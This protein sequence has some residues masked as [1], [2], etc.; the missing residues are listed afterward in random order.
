MR[1]CPLRWRLGKYLPEWEVVGFITGRVKAG[2]RHK[3]VS[4][5]G[6]QIPLCRLGEV[7]E[8]S[9]EDSRLTGAIQIKA[10]R[11]VVCFHQTNPQ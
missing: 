8:N 5:T 11:I 4:I 2:P 6:T 3:T 7:K 1:I 9:R 10:Y